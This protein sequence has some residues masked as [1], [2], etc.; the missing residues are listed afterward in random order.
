MLSFL[1]TP[2]TKEIYYDEFLTLV[3]DGRVESVE[4]ASDRII[5]Y[6]KKAEEEK[7]DIL[8]LYLGGFAGEPQKVYYTG[9]VNDDQLVE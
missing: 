1:T 7:K 8:S 9:N 5:I 2:Q 3:E 6:E 4:I